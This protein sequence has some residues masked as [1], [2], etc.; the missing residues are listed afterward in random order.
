M[1]CQDYK[2]V[3]DVAS[4]PKILQNEPFITLWERINSNLERNNVISSS[5]TIS[6]T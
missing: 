3:V 2:I 4:I 5:W 1:P 6:N